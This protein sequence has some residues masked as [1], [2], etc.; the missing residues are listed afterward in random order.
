MA[1]DLLEESRR[2]RQAAK[3]ART[4]TRDAREELLRERDSR[5]R[6]GSKRREAPSSPPDAVGAARAGGGE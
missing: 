4:A 5:T 3:Q 6:V 1:D 2:L